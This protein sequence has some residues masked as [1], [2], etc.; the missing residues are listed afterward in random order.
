MNEAVLNEPT[1]KLGPTP[2][3]TPLHDELGDLSDPGIPGYETLELLGRGGMGLVWKARQERLNRVVALKVL[4]VGAAATPDERLRFRAEAEAIAQLDHPNIVRVFD[5]GEHAGRAY[6]ALEYVAGGSLADQ[7]TAGVLLPTRAAGLLETL[8]LALQYAHER[9]LIHRDLKPANIL[10]TADGRPRVVDFGLVKRL[11][12]DADLTRTG[13]VMGTPAYMA[14]EQTFSE[15]ALGPAVDV[16]ALG[17]ILYECLTGRPPFLAAAVLETLTQVR[18]LEPVAPRQLNPALPRDLETICLK[19]LRK[20]PAQRYASAR[21]LALDLR[22]FLDGEPIQARP[23]GLAER[24]WTRARRNRAATLAIGMTILTLL[25]GAGVGLAL[26]LY[27]DSEAAR[28][29]ETDLRQAAERFQREAEAASDRLDRLLA[30]QTVQGAVRE[31]A[32]GQ[33]R[34]ARDLLAG[35]PTDRRAWEWHY[36]QRLLHAPREIAG[37]RGDPDTVA[38]TPDGTGVVTAHPRD[39]LRCWDAA[40]GQQRFLFEG[41]Q[42][43][44]DGNAHVVAV[45][46]TPRRFAFGP[47]PNELLVGLGEGPFAVYDTTSGKHLRSVAGPSAPKTC[48][49]L[50]PNRAWVA[51]GSGG[52]NFFV[53]GV[54]LV[55]FDGTPDVRLPWGNEMAIVLAAAP[56]GKYLAAGGETGNVR[57]WD[58]VTRQPVADLRAGQGRVIGLAFR[59][60]SGQ[61]LVASAAGQIRAYSV[62]Q[63]GEDYLLDMRPCRLGALAIHPAGKT[64]AVGTERGEVRTF[65][66][67]DGQEIHTYRGHVGLAPLVQALAY[68]P[69]GRRL[70]SSG[71]RTS[72]VWDVT[73]PQEYDHKHLDFPAPFSIALDGG[74]LQSAGNDGTLRRWRMPT[75]APAGARLLLP[76]GLT[77]LAAAAHVER[78]AVAGRGDLVVWDWQQEREVL[79]LPGVADRVNALTLSG[80]GTL[81]YAACMG[82]GMCLRGWEVATGRPLAGVPVTD[83]LFTSLTLSP[84]GRYLA[85]ADNEVLLVWDRATGQEVHR[86][87]EGVGGCVLKFNA[88]GS[89]LA[90]ATTSAIR[91]W[92]TDGW[93]S[94]LTGRAHAVRDAVAFLADNSRLIVA[95]NELVVWDFAT[96]REALVLPGRVTVHALTVGTDGSVYGANL[97][98]SLYRWDGAPAR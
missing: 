85:A 74:T 69:D 25:L 61:L 79:R 28:R 32:A 93:T 46:A 27:Q 86:A 38:F 8:A 2:I 36:V 55:P 96:G 89:L 35:T 72:R 70:V 53:P 34:R 10:L 17:V 39:G 63:W 68:S 26:W 21:D 9:N 50:D 41:T 23:V 12:S 62:A 18:L 30:A 57:V 47:E 22:R 40:T 16:Y 44:P 67:H 64:F 58:V 52:S 98:G 48:L 56:S 14:P 78:T 59:P 76:L 29:Q 5:V 45:N 54:G 7:L 1:R 82:E 60:D 84:D 81:V 13:L 71:G 94:L 75:G 15:H 77:Y 42:T 66:T 51:F 6:L 4:L 91:V 37:L 20:E 33:E 87:S 11:D 83:R 92:R 73:R 88:D 65:V 49:A 24:L 19:C 31:W 80:D 3:R 97:A 43:G 95:G 90:H